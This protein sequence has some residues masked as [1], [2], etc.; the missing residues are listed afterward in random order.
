MHLHSVEMGPLVKF[1]TPPPN[2]VEA[3]PEAR[4][5]TFS[6]ALV[7]GIAMLNP[8]LTLVL[9]SWFNTNPP[10]LKPL[11]L[12]LLFVEEKGLVRKFD[13]DAV[14]D[15]WWCLCLLRWWWWWWWWEWWWRVEV[16][17]RFGVDEGGAWFVTPDVEMV[18]SERGSWEE[19]D[20]RLELG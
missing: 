8:P 17:W 16:W 19:L 10:L 4:T 9:G 3:A 14:V 11:M 18:D 5:N 7:D 20:L 6:L 2:P 15:R 12:A 1:C 13:V